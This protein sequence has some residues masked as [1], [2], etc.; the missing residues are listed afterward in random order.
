M[1]ALGT[2]IS[3][4]ARRLL[5]LAVLNSTATTAGGQANPESGP[6][7]EKVTVATNPGESD[8]P[9][10]CRGGDGSIWTVWQAYQD[11]SDRLYMARWRE[12]GWS[13][14]AAVPAVRGDLYKPACGPDG[15]GRL[16]LVW[17]QQLDAD[18]DLWTTW[19]DG[20]TWS[21]PQRVIA[22]K[23]TDFVPRIAPA[24]DGSL[25]LVW[26]AWRGDN[27]D[28]M[29][30]RRGDGGWS[31]PEVVTGS[32]GND[33]AP[34]VAVSRQGVVTFV[35][36]S[37]RHGDYDVFLR[38]R[39]GERWSAETAVAGSARFEANARVIVDS[40]ERV[41]I[42]YEERGERWG[43]DRG[44]VTTPGF[45]ETNSL[46]GFSRVKLR[47]FHEGRL[48][49]PL[50]PPEQLPVHREWGGD[51]S[52]TIAISPTGHLWLA[53][54]RPNPDWKKI[55]SF[56]RLIPFAGWQPYAVVFDGDQWSEPVLVDSLLARSDSDLEIAA[57]ADGR[58]LEVWHSDN[59]GGHWHNMPAENRVYAAVL[60]APR[61]RA[62]P[63]RLGPSDAGLDVDAH[64]AAEKERRDVRRAREYRI[65]AK[66]TVHRLYRGDLHRHTDMS[67]DGPSEGSI[68]DLFRYALDAAA[69]DFVA[70]TDH[71]QPPG[72]EMEYVRW[73][74]QKIT[75]LFHAAPHFIPLFGYERSVGYPYGHRNIIEAERGHR[76]LP[77]IR[78]TPADDTERLYQHVHGT[79]GIAIPHTTGSR[80]GTDWHVHDPHVE[81][82]VEIYQGTR[83]SYE[84]EGAP[85]S[86]HPESQQALETGYQAPGFVWEAWKKGYRLGV[87]ASSD[88]IATHITYANIFAPEATREGLVEAMRARHTFGS[89][90]NIVLD[91]RAGE[92]LQGDDV[93]TAS[94][95]TLQVR[96]HGTAP[97][98]E[99]VLFRNF[100]VAHSVRDQGK[101]LTFTWKNE[102]P[103]SGTNHYYVRVLQEDGEIAWS[104]PIWLTVK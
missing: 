91:F 47:A 19:F 55:R 9:V 48:M 46:L 62:I 33:W 96:V 12:G 14:P 52:P 41:W 74:T 58:L 98:Q 70:V 6:P 68:G 94:M 28:V 45:D 87:I 57:L 71:S 7:V 104:S 90:D 59:R 95:P 50:Q 97:I 17:S 103:K 51:R 49:Q 31:T 84:Y 64:A 61:N 81:P 29:L 30:A 75:D 76:P 10:V 13:D 82:V 34:D 27:F 85:R 16:H 26:Q 56:K 102:N 89:T 38:Q 79:G 77:M 4:G 2:L 35:W 8:Y 39:R 32:P 1:P 63:P 69:L 99:V 18:W 53:F 88:H 43:K 23:G 78:P 37:Y 54:K 92:Y 86:D 83:T 60:D 36:D 21:T 80:H 20:A 44:Y 15:R 101:E 5:F 3:P 100:A 93:K 67:W 73:R 65:Q 72:I 24:P 11:G 42:A 25:V 22:R 40:A 66:G